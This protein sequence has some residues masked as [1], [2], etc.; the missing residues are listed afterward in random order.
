M[1]NVFV[2]KLVL[3]GKHGVGDDERAT[4]QEFFIDI[5]AEVDTRTVSA[6]DDIE[7]TAN[8]KDFVKIAREI[9]EGPP[10]RLIET[11]AHKIAER[12]LE[13]HRVKLIR[14]TIRKPKAIFPCMA[15]VTVVRAQR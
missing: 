5:S 11:L 6:T 7:D 14:I 10:C 2:E 13:N 3:A 8:Y 15:G 9:V 1:D 4:E 12:I